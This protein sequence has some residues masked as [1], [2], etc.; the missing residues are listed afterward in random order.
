MQSGLVA[1]ARSLWRGARRRS[2]VDADMNEEFRLHL[3]LRTEDLMRSGMSRQAATRQARLEFGCVETHMEAGAHARGLRRFDGLR[4]SWLDFKLG[5]RMLGRY[6][7]LTIIGGLAMAFAIWVGAGAFEMVRQLVHPRIPLDEGNR[8]VALQLW[9]SKAR[10]PEPRLLHDFEAWRTQLTSIEELSAYRT[11]QRNLIVEQNTSAPVVVAEVSASA[12]RVARVP[13]LMGRALVSSDEKKEAPNVVVLGYDTWQACLGG[14]PHVIGRRVRIGTSPA[15]IVGVMPKGFRFPLI[16][17]AWMPLRLNALDYAV[18]ESPALSGVFGRLAHS[19]S[20]DEAQIEL[21]TVSARRAADFPDTHR[22]LR[23]RLMPYSESYIKLSTGDSLMMMS[24]NVFLVMLL[25]LVAGNVALL[26][27]ARAATRENEI[28]VRGALGAGRGRIVAQFFAEAL[29]LGGMATLVGLTAVRF[30]LQWAYHAILGQSVALPFWFTDQLA[31]ATIIYSLLL[32][33]LGAAIAGVLPALK[34]TRSLEARLRAAAAGASG[35]RFG[36]IWTAV[37]ISQVAVTVGFPVTTYLVRRDIAKWET[38]DVGFS[39][40]Q[41]LSVRLET[42]REAVSNA[43]PG[44]DSRRRFVAASRATIEELRRRLVADPAVLGVTFAERLPRMYHP[45]RLI[46]VDAGG[47]APR[48]AEWPNGYRVSSAAVDASYFEVLQAPIEIG[49]GFTAAE[50][51]GEHRVVVVNESFVRRVLGDRSPIG[52]RLRYV[53]FEEW[54]D[55]HADEQPGPWFEIVGVVRDMGMSVGEFDP[56]ISGI[57]HPLSDTSAASVNM[58]VHVRGDPEAFAA[59]LRAVAYTVDPSLR[60]HD[61]QRLDKVGSS[62]VRL[63]MFWLRMTLI[64]TA[65]ALVLALSGIY[66]VL[67]FIVS[68]RTRE[69]GVRVA[70]GASARHVVLTIF[71]R[72]LL[73]VS[74]GVVVGMVLVVALT[75]MATSDMTPSQFATIVAYSCLMLLVCMLACIVPTRRAL[76]VQPT[77]AL[78]SE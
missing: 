40:A 58:A 12:F 36:G 3:D 7:G 63:L 22:N 61:V 39:S 46:E 76:N 37:I 30:T 32:T 67:S 15:T 10:Q 68:R 55:R 66:A 21:T 29:V 18:G 75:R 24:V 14:D 27:F 74:G 72:P 71:K 25:A 50:M 38:L 52:R 41:Y 49:R 19:T 64:V 35:V 48:R 65:V 73:Q 17:D 69:I 28:I 70:L 53:R 47:A 56:K 31:P 59:R 11:L 5:L 6:P 26:M 1:R 62:E 42:D 60:L 33:V 34:I 54:G 45:A 9:D 20:L 43:S 78:K 16:H 23:A 2:A 77:Q 8:I 57:Y 13:P 4:V 51:Q 44:A